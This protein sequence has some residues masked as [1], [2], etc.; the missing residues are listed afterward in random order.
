MFQNH[1]LTA[2]TVPLMTSLHG[3]NTVLQPTYALHVPG[4]KPILCGI[5]AWIT[6]KILHGCSKSRHH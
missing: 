6:N 1:Y 2:I 3:H 4:L 5:L